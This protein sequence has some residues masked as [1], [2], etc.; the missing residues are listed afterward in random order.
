[1][2]NE[3]PMELKPCPFCGGKAYLRG[4][5]CSQELYSI[6]CIECQCEMQDI[7]KSQAIS[8][9]NN[10]PTTEQP[11]PSAEVEKIAEKWHKAI[12]YQHGFTHQEA[13]TN[14]ITEAT[15]HLQQRVRELE[16]LMEAYNPSDPTMKQQRDEALAR[17]AE[18]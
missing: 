4:G 16:G 17:N 18:L 11:K 2:N 5:E 10:R 7:D 9:W 8:L 12:V 6:H 15:S 14:A 1:M 13:I 3:Q